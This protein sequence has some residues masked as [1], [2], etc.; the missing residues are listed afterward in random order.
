MKRILAC[1]AGALACAALAGAQT[2]VEHSTVTA[3]S[4]A[5][6][7]GMRGVGKSVGRVFEKA[8]KALGQAESR[9][10]RSSTIVIARLDD[11]EPKLNTKAPDAAAIQT[12]MTADDLV[13]KF[14][15]PAMKVNGPNSETWLYGSEPE[16]LTIELKAGKVASVTPPKKRAVVQEAKAPEAARGKADTGVVIIQ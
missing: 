12:G 1:A 14:G 15:P 8:G 4:T 3:G 5:G 13:S 16:V 2:M 10:R 9:G 6:A 11:N 7:A